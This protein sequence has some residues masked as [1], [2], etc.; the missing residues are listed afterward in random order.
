M[1]KLLVMWR[2]QAGS[3]CTLG[4]VLGGVDPNSLPYHQAGWCAV[5]G[6]EGQ[7]AMQSIQV[8]A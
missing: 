3:V 4:E 7:V 1:E 6:G 5:E 2:G 8:P